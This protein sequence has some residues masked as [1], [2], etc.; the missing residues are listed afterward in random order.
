MGY[1]Y[2]QREGTSKITKLFEEAQ[3]QVEIEI[4]NTKQN[5]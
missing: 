1:S 3:I 5:I 4:I 2:I